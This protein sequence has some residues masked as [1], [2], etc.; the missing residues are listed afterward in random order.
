MPLRSL[1]D[2]ERRFANIVASSQP[3]YPNTNT[4][5]DIGIG[6]VDGDLTVA[7]IPEMKDSY[8]WMSFDSFGLSLGCLWASVEPNCQFL[9]FYRPAEREG[10]R[11]YQ[12]WQS[13]YT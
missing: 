5:I 7:N 10:Q 9:Y 8:H 1:F 12:F 3:Q 13:K 11:C 4:T 2:I 6:L